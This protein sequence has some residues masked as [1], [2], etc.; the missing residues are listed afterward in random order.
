MVYFMESCQGS[1]N[2]V[3]RKILS[4]NPSVSEVE[5]PETDLVDKNEK[6]ITDGVIVPLP[7]ELVNYRSK[8]FFAAGFL[9]VGSIAV[10]LYMKDLKPLLFCLLFSSYFVWRGLATAGD[11]R[12]GRIAEIVAT[13]TGIKPS[14]YR[15]RT[16]VTFAAQGEDNALA[17][18]K[19]VLPTRKA[20]EDFIVGA[21]Y[22]VYFD[23]TAS[24]T[25][26]A[27]V[28]IEAESG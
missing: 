25:L 16:T 9:F 2:T 13:C 22:V 19:F 14:F 7:T 21:V 5:E 10:S 27:C 26:I 18:Y 28:Q 17:Y 4:Y 24:H 12:S 3:K 8:N 23:R 6:H 11:Y 15:D 20:E 1:I